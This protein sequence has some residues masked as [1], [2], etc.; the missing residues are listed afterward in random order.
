MGK[1][2]TIEPLAIMLPR[3]DPEPKK[4][5]DDEMKRLIRTKEAHAIYDHWF[6]EP[7]PPKG[8]ALNLPRNYLLKD[9]WKYPTDWVP[10]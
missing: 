1:F 7:I 9:M 2:L 10:G 5:A 6:L 3:D 4:L 8:V